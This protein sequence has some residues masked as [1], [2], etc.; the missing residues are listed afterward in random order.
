MK[1]IKHLLGSLL[2]LSA[3]SLPTATNAQLINGGY[4]TADWQF[5][6]PVSND[7]ANVASG[8][9]MAFEGGYYVI[10]NM[11][12]GLYVSYHT[13]NKYIGEQVLHLSDTESLYTDQQHSIY[14]VP[15]GVAT[16]WRFTTDKMFEPYIGVKLGASYI[17]ME[18]D[19]QV[20]TYYQDRWGFNVQPEIGLNLFPMPTTRVGLH[21]ALYYSYSTNHS[22]VLTYN[23]DGYNN[24]GFRLG[25]SF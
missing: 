4:F 6:A 18:S 23:I 19:T 25:L 22:H 15:F 2:L 11:S 3:M 1:K 10:P 9:G 5:N 13:N 12:L 24:I 7:Y 8:W 21:L 16:R 20:Y 17:R 14:Q